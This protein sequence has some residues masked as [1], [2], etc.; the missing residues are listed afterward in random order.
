[1]L[2]ETFLRYG[3][4]E[5]P[6][7][8]VPLRA[9]PLALLY[10][11]TNGMLRRIKLGEIEVLRG[12]YAAVRDR[13]WGTVPGT[14]REIVRNVESQSFHIEFESEHRQGDIHFIWRGMIRGDANGTVRYEFEGEAQTTF[15]RNRIGFCVLHPI[16][17][18]A[19]ARARQSRADG[20]TVECRFPELIEPQIFGRSSFRE[21][22]AVAHEVAPGLWAQVEFAGDT[23]EM[24]D[25][26]NWTDASFKTYCTPL[27]LPFP[28]EIKQGSRVCQTITLRLT[29]HLTKPH[30]SLIE[31]SAP[32]ETIILTVPDGPTGRLPAI[33][34]GV[35]SHSESL[36]PTEIN[37]LRKLELSHLRA[38]VRLAANYAATTLGRAAREAMQLNT[39]LELALYLPR[40]G[41]VD[42]GELLRVLEQSTVPLTRILALR[43]GEPATSPE[44]LA[45]VRKHFGRFGAP[46]GA[47]SDSNFCELNR[48]QAFGRFASGDSDFI[49]W[50]LNPQVHAFDH[51]SIMETLE[52]QATTLWSACAFAAGRPLTISPVTLKQRFNPVA[53]GQESGVAPDEL[54]PQV[55]PRQLS[56]FGA[57]WTLGSIAALAATDIDSVTFY[58]TTGW[59]GVM[60]R[61]H[62]ASLLGRFPSTPGQTFPLFQVFADLAGFK[63]FAPV[64]STAPT[65]VVALGL[66]KASRLTRLFIAN[67]TDQVQRVAVVKRNGRDTKPVVL[68][69][70]AVARLDCAD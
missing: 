12:I 69:P 57:A 70:F 39:G 9:G 47:G 17:E 32:A 7:E 41:E 33:G 40:A 42:P 64:P 5:P 24:E 36:E 4:P 30:P 62:G 25:Q 16:R 27:A 15:L 35:A 13:N 23:F 61:V 53:T 31:V 55:D 54:P 66:F 59:R 20:T 2:T 50:S 3:Q 22:R 48:E 14:M 34:L 43:E 60:E 29:G 67:L 37:T 63:D 10:D 38:D 56:L 45:W 58:E 28:V 19:G 21:L 44:T 52:A 8:L 46:I 18:C 6:A 65:Q 68:Q 49:F 11:P 26:R 51:R 1:M